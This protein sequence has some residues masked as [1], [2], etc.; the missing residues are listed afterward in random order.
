[1]RS[2]SPTPSLPRRSGRSPALPYPPSRQVQCSTGPVGCSSAERQPYPNIR[3]GEFQTS[4]IE[5]FQTSVDRALLSAEKQ[6]VLGDLIAS[7]VALVSPV[8]SDETASSG[9]TI[10]DR[11]AAKRGLLRDAD[12]AEG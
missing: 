4:A 1:M 5:E 2:A 8:S 6:A 11:S 12:E 9:L 3:A 10:H 7:L